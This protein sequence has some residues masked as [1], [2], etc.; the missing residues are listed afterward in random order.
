M[1]PYS[2][3]FKTAAVL[4]V[5]FVLLL[6]CFRLSF[7]SAAPVPYDYVIKNGR[8]MN[9]STGHDL[10]GYSLAISNG[11]IVKISKDVMNGK[12]VIDAKGLVVSPG[13][14]DL[15]SYE[16]TSIGIKLK[17][18]DGV[19]SNL[20]M[21]G[22]TTNAGSWYAAKKRQ[23]QILNYGA[24]SFIM[25]MRQKYVGGSVDAV[26]KKSS[27]INGLA[28]DVRRNIKDGALGVSF[29][30]EYAPGIQ[31]NEIIPLM[32]IAKE[33][34]VP[35]FWHTR[36]SAF[37]PPN[38]GPAGIKEV[39]SYAKQ[40][41][42]AVN[43]MHINSTGGTGHMA[44]VLKMC[45]DARKAGIDITSDIY[46]YNSWATY[47]G[48][49]RFRT[50]WQE[51]FN[52]SYP[53]LQI[54]GTNTI[55]TKN[56]FSGY[57]SKNV[58]V[59]ANGSIP[60][61]DNITALKDPTVMLGS[62]TIITSG[63]NHPRGA[64][65]YSR[66]F[67]HYVRDA[68]AISLMDAISK[69]SYQPA[70]RME[71]AAPSMKRKGRLEI[72]CDADVTIFNPNTIKDNATVRNS[73][74]ASTGVEYVFVN[75]VLIKDK[76][77]LHDYNLHHGWKWD[78][79]TRRLYGKQ[80]V[81]RDHLVMEIGNGQINAGKQQGGKYTDK[82]DESHQVCIWKSDIGVLRGMEEI[83]MG[84]RHYKHKRTPVHDDSHP[85]VGKRRCGSVRPFGCYNLRRGKEGTVLDILFELSGIHNIIDFYVFKSSFY[86]FYKR[87]VCN[88]LYIEQRT[89][90][91]ASRAYLQVF[92]NKLLI[93]EPFSYERCIYPEQFI[94]TFLWAADDKLR[95][96]AFDT[97]VL[98]A[99]HIRGKG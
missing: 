6:D 79:L 72:G 36:Y 19:T 88:I 3:N 78:L 54:G 85:A 71:S 8:I 39:I 37:N 21:H 40:T 35:T 48:S 70:K 46:T 68:K 31:K 33:Y 75:G 92:Y 59:C 86:F 42:A 41:G 73:A 58:L 99:L 14:I 57:R 10:K 4:A 76:G 62:D 53:N 13:F 44:E 97:P 17:V 7:V 56:T 87:F 25:T 96:R 22:G 98:P 77:N 52:I 90:S 2:R 81:R 64:G 95:I 84:R 32:K 5:I 43:F 20:L 28:N 26:L 34:D 49:A 94:K 51:R 55:I 80:Q 67:A 83:G 65:N 16:P 27:Q 29:S 23:G 18:F 60:E 66:L 82:P 63:N 45:D 61:A 74:A 9:P 15:I 69:V 38:N 1:Q 11:K 93:L 30:L 12:R 50:G 89:W 24:S 91:L 47:L